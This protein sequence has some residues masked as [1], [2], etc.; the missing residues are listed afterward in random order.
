MPGRLGTGPLAADQFGLADHFDEL[1]VVHDGQPAVPMPVQQPHDVHE[2]LY[3][4][5]ST[6][7]QVITSPTMRAMP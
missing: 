1:V 2:R 7:S 3:Q 4:R 5:A 6:T